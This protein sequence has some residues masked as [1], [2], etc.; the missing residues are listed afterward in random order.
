MNYSDTF[1][2]QR[3]YEK[4]VVK[5]EWLLDD[6]AVPLLLG[7]D[8]ASEFLNAECA[9]LQIKVQAAVAEGNLKTTDSENDEGTSHK[10]KPTTIYHWAMANK[11]KL[12]MELVNLMEF[13]LKTIMP[14][15]QAPS[16][17]NESEAMMDR[18]DTEQILGACFA[19]V[20]TF[21]DDISSSMAKT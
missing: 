4:W 3:L 19:L 14:L 5:D 11:L 10:V 1:A 6:E 2:L 12:P 16:L 21:P 13:V 17:Q 8:P 18:G 7:L 9:L 15:Q 20:T